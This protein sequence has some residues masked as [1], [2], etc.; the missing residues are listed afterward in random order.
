M[1]EFLYVLTYGN[2][3]VTAMEIEDNIDLNELL[4]SELYHWTS[5]YTD[6]VKE[7]G[8]IT[9]YVNVYEFSTKKDRRQAL[10]MFNKGDPCLD[11]DRRKIT[12]VICIKHSDFL[13]YCNDNHLFSTDLT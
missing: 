12:N 6:F 4:F 1:K 8:K 5:D 11:E 2:D 7:Y 9:A 13:K 10:E 3:E